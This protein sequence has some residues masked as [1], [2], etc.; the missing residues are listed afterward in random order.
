MNY[1][2]EGYNAQLSAVY[3]NTKVGSNPK[4]GKVVI[5]MQLQY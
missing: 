2:I 4:N 5:A 3:S 1:I